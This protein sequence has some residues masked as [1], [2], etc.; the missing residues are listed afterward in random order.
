MAE[1]II[2]VHLADVYEKPDRKGYIR[3]LG[4]GDVVDV[5]EESKDYVKIQT[6]K[7]EDM[8]DGSMKPTNL[9][10]YIV[11]PN[12]GDIKA[13]D[14]TISKD[15]NNILQVD[16]VDVQQGDACVI[17]T[18][19][20]K[21]ILIDGGDNQLFARYLAGRFR[22]TTKENPKKIDCIV[23]SHGD[24][25]HFQGLTEIYSS[26]S[27]S[28]G[29]KRIFIQPD[30]IYH[31]GLVKRPSNLAEKDQLGETYTKDGI[32]IITGLKENLLEVPDEDMNKPF[33]AWK[34]ALIE[35]Q[36]RGKIDFRR[37]SFCDS[38]RFD[39]IKNEGII[40]KVFGP[41]PTELDGKVGLK[42]LGEP[43][44]GP[45]ISHE[46]FNLDMASF[47]GKSVSHTI[48][49]HSIVLKITYGDFSFLLS[50]DLNEESSRILTKKHES[51]EI[52]LTSDVFKVPHHGSADFSPAL[53]KAVS[54]VVSVV[55]SGDES[56]R[57]EYIHP[58]ATL[59]GALGRYS[60]TLEPLV[61]VTELV[62]F[63]NVEGY[64]YPEKHIIE[65]GKVVMENGE[66]K[67]NEKARGKFF[68]FSRTA[69]GIVKI[70]TNGKQLLIY[71]NSGQQKL[72]EA[73]AYEKNTNEEVVP[74]K[75]QK[76]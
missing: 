28:I 18:P 46:A 63:F 21:V 25:D 41:I 57:K 8:E 50:G 27:H 64:V 58:R 60:R 30:R 20:N 1:K 4:W 56:A 33:K 69:F 32:I 35:Y 14:V 72:K 42:F 37:V 23:V 54:P 68:A 34:K 61:F 43:E 11:P 51:G 52:D 62:A 15:V 31:N 55:S 73:Y 3:T 65:Y 70:R 49:G 17:E 26:E 74:L 53:L 36:K 67:I 40:I 7:F 6:V 12:N 59:M 24:A 38:S 44:K 5:L 29:S 19:K 9:P 22:N 76:I 47:K 66:P 13:Q 48:N 2:N 10:G 16:F 71:T 39:F 75:V 45:R